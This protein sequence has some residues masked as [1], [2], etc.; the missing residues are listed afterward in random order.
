MKP[1]PARW[2]LVHHVAVLAVAST[3]VACDKGNAM[4]SRVLFS[5]VQGQVLLQGKPVAGAVVERQFEWNNETS[6]DRVS[7]GADGNFSFAA[8]TRKTSFMDRLLPSEP[9]VK[10]TILIL[11]D[12]KSHKAWH[13]FKRNYDNNG[14]L[15]GRAIRMTCR[16][17]REPERRGEVFGI[18]EL[19]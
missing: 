18:C 19:N 15:G 13:H 4:S 9:M 6:S 3:L 10:Q 2:A 8:V 1:N 12:G 5:A 16:L 7:S 17:E 11:H 14:E